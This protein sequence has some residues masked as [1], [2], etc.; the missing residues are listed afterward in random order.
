MW[1][2]IK[3]FLSW[4]LSPIM[5][6]LDFP[7]LPPEVGQIVS[8]TS[9]YLQAG[10]GVLNFFCPL[11]MI[12]PAVTVFIAVWTVVHGYHLVMWVLRKIPFVGVQ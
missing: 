11:S 4:I 3:G 9:E 10:A 5:S 2:L 8:K 1:K 7:V 12:A 6:V